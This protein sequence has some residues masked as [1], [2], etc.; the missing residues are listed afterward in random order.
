MAATHVNMST[1]LY[2]SFD[3]FVSNDLSLAMM[4]RH[5]DNALATNFMEVEID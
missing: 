1:G 5:A 3:I 4:M 2:K